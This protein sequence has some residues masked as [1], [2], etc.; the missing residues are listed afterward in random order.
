[1]SGRRIAIVIGTG[2]Y[3]NQVLPDL[4]GPAQDAMRLTKVLQDQN[5]G[6]YE[7]K[8]FVNSSSQSVNKAIEK[9]FAQTSRDDT[10]L[11]YYSGHG[12]RNRSGRL[13]FST[14]DTNKD[15]LRSTAV[16]ASFVNEVMNE[17]RSKNQIMLLDCCYSGSFASGLSDSRGRVVIT[18]SSAIQ[19]SF[20]IKEENEAISTSI[21][22]RTMIDG[23]ETGEADLNSDGKITCFELFN[24]IICKLEDNQTIQTPKLWAF[25]LSGDIVVIE[26][27]R[28]VFRAKTQN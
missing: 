18:S 17:S 15:M 5:F 8:M 9:F 7:V 6:K 26:S 19:S 27:S 28:K 24:Y 20:E 4:Q 12:I 13:Y 25:D 14:T 22:T 1:M 10:V 23:L 16:S 21:F 11:F 2:E 3:D